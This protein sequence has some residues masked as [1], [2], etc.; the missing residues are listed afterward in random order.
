MAEPRNEGGGPADWL[1]DRVLRGLIAAALALPY[2]R[3]VPI[4]GA[5]VRRGIGPLAGYRARAIRHLGQIY[6]DMP[7]ARRRRIADAVTDN[8]GRTLIENYSHHELGQR[9]VGT[10]VTGGG[11]E[12]L[13][14]ARAEG[15]P[16][17]FVTGH[18]GNYEAPR[19]VLHGMGYRIGGIYRA[20]SNPFFN[21]HYVRTMEDVSG[22]VFEK[23]RRGTIGFARHLKS[24]GMAT[25]LFDI[26]D[27][28]GIQV[29][30]L[31]RPAWTSTSAADLAL[32]FD[33]ALIP[34]FGTRRRDGL[35]F[36]VAVEAPVAPASPRAMVEEMTARLAARVEADPGQ[37]FWVHNRWKD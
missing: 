18:F 9:L 22:P 33:A 25:I 30:F 3:R 26:H 10:P 21:S 29:D 36:D 1:A 34:Y 14:A 28:Q 23:G 19:H 17:I 24:G 32:K 20:M 15:R 13:A 31:G 35:G 5:V 37:W 27:R 12:A 8:A 4:M 2:R 16:V 11:M 7:P 6:P